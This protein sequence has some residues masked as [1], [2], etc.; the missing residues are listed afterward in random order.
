MEDKPSLIIKTKKNNI[1]VITKYNN[2]IA[3]HDIQL[4]LVLGYYWKNNLPLIEKFIELLDTII[5]RSLNQVFPHKILSIRY[6]IESNDDLEE[7]SIYNITLLDVKADDEPLE[8][9]GNEITLEGIDNRGTISKMT[10]FRRKVNE[11]FEKELIF[12]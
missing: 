11:T 3:E 6:N 10:S 4:K 12:E 1:I 8:L 9:S 5:K 2:E 7:A